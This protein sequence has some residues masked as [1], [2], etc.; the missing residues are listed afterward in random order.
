MR[1]LEKYQNGINI[2][3]W[4]SQC[5][6]YTQ[7]HYLEFITENDI[8]NI[9]NMGFDHIRVPVDYNVIQDQNG[10][11]IESGLT[12]IDNCIA[13]AR[14]YSL[15]M[16]L[17]LHKTAGYSFDEYESSSSFFTDHKLQDQ[18]I[19][20]WR[21]LAIRYGQNEDMLAFEILNEIVDT[22]VVEQWNQIAKRCILTIR[23][24][25]P[26]ITI[27]LGGVDYNSVNSIKLLEKPLDEN[28]VYNFHCY[29]PLIF[30]HQNAHWVKNMIPNY[31]T[32][33]PKTLEEYQEDTKNTGL[34]YPSPLFD[35]KIKKMGKEFFEQLFEE[36]IRIATERNVPLYC[37]EFGVI[38]QAPLKDTL[39][40]YQ[41]IVS[42]F[43]KYNIGSAIWNYKQMDFGLID[44]H[45]SAIKDDIVSLVQR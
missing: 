35:P 5:S 19:N 6:E 11:V 29:E 4:I 1:I 40:W 32:T 37:G 45:Y 44:P 38:D 31:H 14:K 21:E 15:N 41:D 2:G 8:L 13:W 30:T 18:F 26:T 34:F 42:I 9:R 12:H 24:F 36:A 22:N 23:E 39:A 43:K 20:L 17:D 16:I 33:Y 10:A 25:C 3:G 28:I 27:L 7:E